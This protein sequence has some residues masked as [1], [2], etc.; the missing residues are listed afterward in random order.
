METDDYVPVKVF[1]TLIRVDRQGYTREGYYYGAGQNGHR[2]SIYGETCC[3]GLTQGFV[4][5]RDG[6]R[7]R[8]QAIKEATAVLV[9][10][11]HYR[12]DEIVIE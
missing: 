5:G 10:S 1:V 12:P 6:R 3:I 2:W 4:R 7:T 8:A 11:G 9:G